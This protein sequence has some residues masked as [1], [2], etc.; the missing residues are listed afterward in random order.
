MGGEHSLD[1]ALVLQPID[2][3]AKWVT[4]SKQPLPCSQAKIRSCVIENLQLVSLSPTSVCINCQDSDFLDA[5]QF[6]SV[7]TA[8]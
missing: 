3:T 1:T 2:A 6:F 8:S 5:G 4:P 7:H